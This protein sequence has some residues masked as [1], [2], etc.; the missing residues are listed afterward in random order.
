MSTKSVMTVEQFARMTTA[1]TEDFELVEG[2]LIPLSGGTRRHCKIRD[3]VVILMQTYFRC[4]RVGEA[5]GYI[6]CR[7]S[8]DTVHK[9]D[10]SIFLGAERLRQLEGDTIP[11]PIAPDIAVEVLSPS[12]SAIDVRRKVQDYLRAGAKEV[13]LI[14]H[15][16][17]EVLVHSASGPRVLQGEDALE[18]G[19]LPGFRVAVADLVV[20]I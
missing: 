12:E 18:S 17:A 4:G 3:F 10:V 11:L 7:L 14:D 6:D 15:E 1:E 9:P 13:W 8:E 20:N 5:I 2:E 16:N 19:L